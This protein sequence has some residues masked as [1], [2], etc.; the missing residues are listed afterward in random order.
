MGASAYVLFWCALSQGPRERSRCGRSFL[1]WMGEFSRRVS[2][3]EVSFRGD[4]TSGS[5]SGDGPNSNGS[6]VRGKSPQLR[7]TPCDS[8]VRGRSP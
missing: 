8:Q 5:G 7:L 4:V 1:F 3:G 2:K 6:W